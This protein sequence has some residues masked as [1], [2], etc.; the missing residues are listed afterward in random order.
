MIAH[1]IILS[2]ISNFFAWDYVCG[3]CT[4]FPDIVQKPLKNYCAIASN[5]SLKFSHNLDIESFSDL[6][7]LTQMK[8]MEI[9]FS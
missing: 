2:K 9:R 7:I 6:L 5:L 3:E 1:S 8:F 4:V